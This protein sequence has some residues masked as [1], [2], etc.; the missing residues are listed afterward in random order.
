MTLLIAWCVMGLLCYAM[1]VLDINQGYLGLFSDNHRH[2]FVF[3]A[4]VP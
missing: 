2:F 4:V 3:S 1:P